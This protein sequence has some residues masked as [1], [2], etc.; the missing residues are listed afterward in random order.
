[1]CPQGGSKRDLQ[2]LGS[3]PSAPLQPVGTRPWKTRPP[4]FHGLSRVDS[5]LPQT[6]LRI[7][8]RRAELPKGRHSP[9]SHQSAQHAP[10][11][12]GT[13]VIGTQAHG[14]PCG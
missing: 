5:W 7:C 10:V 3:G 12:V 1:M 14:D 9:E 13:A 6:P 4:E 11:L 8:S 2:S